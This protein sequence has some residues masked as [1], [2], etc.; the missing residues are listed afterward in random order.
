[1]MPLKRIGFN[2]GKGKGKGMGDGPELVW[3]IEAVEAH[4]IKS[5]GTGTLRYRADIPLNERSGAPVVVAPL[6]QNL[7]HVH[8]TRSS[9]VA[10]GRTPT[11]IGRAPTRIDACT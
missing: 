11:R 7:C 4:E 9:A 5:C 1:M 6:A 8:G 3:P 2:K 10:D